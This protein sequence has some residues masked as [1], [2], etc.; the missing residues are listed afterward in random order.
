MTEIG[1]GFVHSGEGSYNGYQVAS[2]ILELHEITGIRLGDGKNTAVVDFTLKRTDVTPF[3]NA[4][5]LNEGD[6]IEKQTIF[7]LYDDGWRITE[8]K[9]KSIIKKKNIAGFDSDFIEKAEKE[10]NF[11]ELDDITKAN[12]ETTHFIIQVDNL[13]VRETPDL[14]SKII[15]TIKHSRT[16][17][18]SL[19]E[20]TDFKTTVTINGEKITN[21][22]YKIKTDNGNIGWIHGCC[23]NAFDG[24]G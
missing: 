22:W 14:D 16:T 7:Q 3:G 21:Y 24:R 8:K 23:F 15:E 9:P 11:S 13:R 12:M 1:K 4:M 10:H 5:E 2:S 19:K 6:V 20:K 17:V 18:E